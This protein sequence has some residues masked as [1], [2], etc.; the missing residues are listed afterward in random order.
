MTKPRRKPATQ[1]HAFLV[2]PM[3]GFAPTNWRQK[4][5]HYRILEYVGPKHFKGSA[6]SWKFLHNHEALLRGETQRWAIYLDFESAVFGPVSC[7]PAALQPVALGPTS[8]PNRRKSMDGN[9]LG[10]F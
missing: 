1:F 7:E 3:P 6:D 5:D 8:D 2:E 10:R 9:P 4:P